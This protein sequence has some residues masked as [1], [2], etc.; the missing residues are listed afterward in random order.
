MGLF[1]A[2]AAILAGLE[3]RVAAL[4]ASTVPVLGTVGDGI[5]DD[6]A[7]FAS[8]L[9]TGKSLR[10]PPGVYLLNPD[11]LA[12]QANGQTIFG[13]GRGSTI[14]RKR[15]SGVLL[16]GSGASTSARRSYCGLSD[17]TLSG[18]DHTGSLLKL[19]YSD[20]FR[21]RD[22]YFFDNPD[23]TMEVTEGWDNYFFGCEWEWCGGTTDGT[24]CVILSNSA[25]DS[26]N[27]QYFIGCRWESFG[28]G[29]LK[30]DGSARNLH[31]VYL[32]NCHVETHR[33]IDGSFWMTMSGDTRNVRIANS[34]FA[35]TGVTSGM[36]TALLGLA[37]YSGLSVT[38]CNFYVA[39]PLYV[40]I[41]ASAGGGGNV[42]RDIVCEA[43]V[44]PRSIYNAENALTNWT[45]ENIAWANPAETAPIRIGA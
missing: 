43:P 9:A 20:H 12:F 24:Q 30:M 38:G 26:T 19:D 35:L 10:V 28:Y 11:A 13:S 31:S 22:V 8:A 33:G 2:P 18:D 17:I 4:E 45:I 29:F 37:G 21:G 14:L 36:V 44:V 41:T 42:L 6:T 39:A 23:H 5:V 27:Q 32:T 25:G 7:A 1:N 16:N 40:P 3:V 34:Y 15:G